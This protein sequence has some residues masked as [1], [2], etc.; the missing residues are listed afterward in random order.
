MWK[1]VIVMA[2]LIVS[3]ILAFIMFYA[4]EQINKEQPQFDFNPFAHALIAFLFGIWG[5]C[6]SAGYI[7]IKVYKNV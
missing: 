6:I 2:T 7:A 5:V 1:V 3:T 4:V